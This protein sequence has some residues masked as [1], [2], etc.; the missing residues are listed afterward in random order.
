MNSS[1]LKKTDTTNNNNLL[2]TFDFNAIEEMDP[3]LGNHT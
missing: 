2:S 3:S 1:T